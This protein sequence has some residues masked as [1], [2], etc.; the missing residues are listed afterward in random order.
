MTPEEL[1]AALRI[2][3]AWVYIDIRDV[4]VGGY[5]EAA[6]GAVADG[7][8][9]PP[10]YTVAWSGQYEHLGAHSTMAASRHPPFS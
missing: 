7:V 2:P 4:D 5:V 1:D 3:N 8:A 6:R 10:G 9:L